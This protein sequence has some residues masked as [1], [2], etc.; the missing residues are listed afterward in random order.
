MIVVNKFLVPKYF[1]G[2]TIYPVIILRNKRLLQDR[3]FVNH[4][5]IHLKQ[6]LELLLVF[7]YGWY[8]AEFLF[9]YVKFRNKHQAYRAI[10]FEREAYRF[11]SDLEYL[12]RRSRFAFMKL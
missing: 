4:E 12:N 5:K 10:R 2:I 6:Q 9:Y 8:L 11:E 1:E 3:V 7:F